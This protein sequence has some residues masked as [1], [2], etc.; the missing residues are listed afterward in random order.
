MNR[1]DQENLSSK[2]LITMTKEELL[3]LFKQM[4][5]SVQKVVQPTEG[6]YSGLPKFVTGI[7]GL[8]RTLNLSCSTIARWKADGILDDVTFQEGKSVIFDVHGLLDK[9]RVSNNNTP[10]NL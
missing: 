2:V 10:L 1:K 6:K 9:L 4:E 5:A 7:K 3:D 8:A